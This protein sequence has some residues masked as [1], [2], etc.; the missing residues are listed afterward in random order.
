M[1]IK[2][3]DCVTLFARETTPSKCVFYVCKM[4]SK[5]SPT[6]GSKRR[7]AMY[8]RT[9]FKIDFRKRAFKHTFF[10]EIAACV[11]ADI[12]SRNPYDFTK[13]ALNFF[14]LFP[15]FR[16]KRPALFVIYCDKNI[17]A[18]RRCN[19]LSIDVSFLIFGKKI[20]ILRSDE[21]N[22]LRSERRRENYTV[23]V[24]C[25]LMYFPMSV[26]YAIG[27]YQDFSIYNLL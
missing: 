18:E 23:T 13:F 20:K 26:K 15:C 8:P 11:S 22:H 10:I 12:W 3:K 4:S 1:E 9:T 21:T 16:T 2:N 14:Y 17:S 27:T 25:I 5:F 19:E 24:F 6:C 7:W